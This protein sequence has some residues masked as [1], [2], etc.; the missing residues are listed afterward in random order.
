MSPEHRREHGCSVRHW[1]LRGACWKERAEQKKKQRDDQER[2]QAVPE[3]TA[4]TAQPTGLAI[5]ITWFQRM[6]SMS[7]ATVWT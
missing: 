4:R 3:E 7:P 1:L 6:L 2:H 5:R